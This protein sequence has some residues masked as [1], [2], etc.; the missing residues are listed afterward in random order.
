MI[1]HTFSASSSLYDFAEGSSST[2]EAMHDSELEQCL[3][4][5]EQSLVT[6]ADLLAVIRLGLTA[7]APKNCGSLQTFCASTK[8]QSALDFRLDSNDDVTPEPQM[9]VEIDNVEA[10][11]F[12]LQ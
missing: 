3:L 9:E 7:P 8:K 10:L 12:L 1:P 11:P 4:E 2:G 5:N 6:E